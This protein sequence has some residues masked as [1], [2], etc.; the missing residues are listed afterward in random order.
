MRKVRAESKIGNKKG[1]KD[2]WKKVKSGIYNQG[3]P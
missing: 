1:L 2:G 3:V